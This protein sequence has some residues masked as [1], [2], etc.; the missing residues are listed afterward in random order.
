MRVKLQRNRTQLAMPNNRREI[1]VTRH[2]SAAPGV[3]FDAW[4]DPA[5]ARRFLFATD[6]GQIVRCD[7]DARVGGGFTIVDRRAEGDAEHVGRY[8]ELDRPKRLVFDF[9]VSNFST[10]STRITVSFAPADTGTDV[11]LTSDNIPDEHAERATHGWNTILGALA[12][13]VDQPVG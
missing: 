7:I 9:T 13:V 4:L 3:V 1:V 8:V 6:K 2:F 11:T 10:D 12:R 5:R